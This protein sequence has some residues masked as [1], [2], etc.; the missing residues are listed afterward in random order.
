MKTDIADVVSIDLGIILTPIN[1]TLVTL[2]ES[3]VNAM[4]KQNFKGIAKFLQKILQEFAKEVFQK[5]AKR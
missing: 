5:W 4:A 2:Y 1:K 3:L